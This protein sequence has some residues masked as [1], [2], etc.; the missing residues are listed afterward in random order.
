MLKVRRMW[1]VPEETA[2]VAKA[3]FPKGNPYLLLRDKLGVLFEDEAFAE[4]FEWRGQPAE[5]P[6]FLATVTILQF[7][8]G[9]SDRQTV[10]AIAG[11]ID[12]KYVL[13]LELTESGIA[14]SVLSQFRSRLLA[15]E[16]EEYLLSRMLERLRE[17]GWLKER[18]R[19]RTDSTHILAAIRMLNRTEMIGETMRNVL[20]DLASV[21]P[22][23][24]QAQ[25]TPD[26]YELYGPRFESYR[27]PAKAKEREALQV[28]MG[29]DG[30]HLLQAIYAAAGMA[31]LWELPSVQILRQV[32]IQQ[33]YL[34]GEQLFVRHRDS[35]GLPPNQHLIQSPY[36]PEARVRTKRNNTWTGYSLHVS[37]TCDADRPAL[38]TQVT[39]TPATAGDATVLPTIQEDLAD[40][41]LLP[42]TQIVDTG[43]CG[44]EQL[45]QSRLSHQIDLVGPLPINHSW[46]TK[47]PDAYELDAFRID[48]DA[49]VVTCPQGKQSVGWHLR[50]TPS[51][52]PVI[53][54]SF[55]RRDCGPCPART[56]CTKRKDGGARG[57]SFLPKARHELLQQ[58]RKRQQTDPF[59]ELYRLRAGVESTFSQGVRTYD[60]RRSRYIGLAKTH[61]QHIAT[62]AAMNLARLAAWLTDAPKASTRHSRFAALALNP[63]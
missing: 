34:E 13:G 41:E 2:R 7:S 51:D 19:Q 62:A 58:A 21:A 6:G 12:W 25:V 44:T 56:L 15:G 11:R 31:W 55:S 53:R 50:S 54:V 26:W 5:S 20:N 59:W 60:L 38:I 48:W 33:F 24:V 32:W 43:Y 22:E 57:L 4:L 28:R 46:Q 40:K 49:E 35:Q 16:K 63:A 10:A 39:T 36:D 29:R 47:D 37:E 14:H 42:S 17:G 30:V 8:E 23:W 52:T 3:A 61:L 18:G 9:L 1:N 45:I 27:L